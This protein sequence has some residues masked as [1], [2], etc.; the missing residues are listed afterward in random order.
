MVHSI[1]IQFIVSKLLFWY[2]PS[3]SKKFKNLEEKGLGTPTHAA[4]EGSQDRCTFAGDVYSF[5]VTTWEMFYQEE[6]YKNF[7][8]LPET[9]DYINS[10]KCLESDEK[11]RGD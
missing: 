9:K 6:S 8:T 10:G 5:V 2:F 11:I 4:P 1:L 7:K 3:Y